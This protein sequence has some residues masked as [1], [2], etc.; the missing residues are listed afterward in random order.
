MAIY[1]LT[2]VLCRADKMIKGNEMII[3]YSR[4]GCNLNCNE[5]KIILADKQNELVQWDKALQILKR[6]SASNNRPC[7]VIPTLK[8]L[9]FS[10]QSL[11]KS[12]QE[13]EIIDADIIV[14]DRRKGIKDLLFADVSAIARSYSGSHISRGYKERR[15]RQ[16]GWHSRAVFGY[17]VVD[18]QFVPNPAEWEIAKD[19]ISIYKK[20]RQ[21]RTTIT[22]INQKYPGKEWTVSALRRWVN[23]PALR[24]HTEHR[25]PGEKAVINY[26]THAAL[27]AEEEGKEI[28]RML[29]Q[30]RS[31]W[32]GNA[33][34][35]DEPYPLK[36]KVVCGVCG[37]NCYRSTGGTNDLMRCR[38]RD[39]SKE[40]C[41]NSKS[42]G[43]DLCED[44]VIKLLTKR[45]SEITDIYIE[46]ISEKS[47]VVD[48]L[49][50]QIADLEDFIQEHGEVICILG[51][52]ASLKFDLQNEQNRVQVK[53]AANKESYKMMLEP[54]AKQYDYWAGMTECDR[55]IVYNRLVE[56]VVVQMGEV[57]K[58]LLSI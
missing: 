31:R 25:V 44:A 28:E 46:G 37:S 49:E 3:G 21:F 38:K 6:E 32:K 51:A 15:G 13:I 5:C 9:G 18:N 30:S 45:S 50:K 55:I 41:D 57:V 7:L 47:P 36:G 11:A 43:L 58:V 52:I 56:K 48:S 27:I 23:Y 22:I 8:V 2:A 39:E 53:L 4:E 34:K 20:E 33:H 54:N 26:S 14:K 17:K 35:A 19:I 10:Y 1:A 42:T 29:E 16:K 24:G 40:L 12:L